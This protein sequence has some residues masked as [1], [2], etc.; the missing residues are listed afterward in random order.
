MCEPERLCIIPA[1]AGSKGVP[2]K[3]IREFMGKP[4]LVH[5]I[6]QAIESGQFDTI[7]VSSDSPLYLDI[8]REAGA[9]FLIDRPEYLASDT[10]TTIDVLVHALE[11]A[12]QIKKKEF[13]SVCLLQATSPLRRF[14]D[15]AE[16]IEV[17][18]EGG[19]DSVLSV[20]EA[21]NSPYFNLVEQKT[22][23]DGVE[24]SKQLNKVVTRRQD[25][26][27]IYQI[28]GS[29]YVWSRQA[30]IQQRKSLCTKTGIYLMPGLRSVDIDSEED[31][32]IAE[33][34]AQIISQT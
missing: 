21:K 22:S 6:E 13:A 23:G 14:G 15:I 24:I 2:N 31:W 3:N 27:S 1:R 10:A 7:A 29:I 33:A 8:A 34:F 4:L 11:E 26:P 30:L 12:E 16:A 5:S 20:C 28:N 19:F 32:K 9:N 18:E 25:A 17:R